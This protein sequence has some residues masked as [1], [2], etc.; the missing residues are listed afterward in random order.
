MIFLRELVI[1]GDLEIELV[2]ERDKEIQ[3]HWIESFREANHI[4]G[5]FTRQV[6]KTYFVMK[7]KLIMENMKYNIYI[8]DQSVK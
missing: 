8:S 3:E 4:C 2:H 5:N 6:H 7:H 1:A